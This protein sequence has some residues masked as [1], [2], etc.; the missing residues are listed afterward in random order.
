V[1]P[2]LRNVQ[3]LVADRLTRLAVAIGPDGHRVHPRRHLADRGQLTDVVQILA[4]CSHPFRFDRDG[5]GTLAVGEGRM[6]TSRRGAAGP[7]RAVRAS[8]RTACG[9]AS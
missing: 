9:A 4:H 3:D 2:E 1:R 8:G 6:P 7:A 5:A